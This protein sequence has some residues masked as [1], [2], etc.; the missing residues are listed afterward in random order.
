[1]KSATWKSG[2]MMATVLA[3][4]V[5][6]AAPPAPSSGWMADGSAIDS[7]G[8]IDG[9]ATGSLTY[10]AGV[11]GQAFSFDGNGSVNLPHNAFSSLASSDTTIVAWLKTSTRADTAAV[12][13]QDSWLLYF[14]SAQ[15]GVITGVWNDWPNRLSSGVDIRDGQWHHVASVY[16]GGIA[17]IYVDGIFRAS[18]ARSRTSSSGLSSFG[19]GYFANY[20]GLIDDVGIYRHALTQDEIRSVMEEGLAAAVPEPAAYALLVVGLLVVGA[21]ATRQV[22]I[23]S[24]AAS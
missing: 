8:S 9:T 18:G 4:S 13:F 15:P 7:F 3:A 23:N 14:D 24:G 22:R 5:A 12:K 17:S 10:A 20:L 16:A 2:L 21:A 19:A 11:F 6:S 1:M